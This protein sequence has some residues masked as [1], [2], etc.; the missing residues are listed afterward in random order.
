MSDETHAARES[1][2]QVHAHLSA[3]AGRS[4]LS[5]ARGAA[6]LLGPSI[7][8]GLVAPFVF[9]AMRRAAGPVVK[10]LLK[11]ALSLGESIKDGAVEARE[12][13]ADTLAE[14]K[15]EREREAAAEA[16]TKKTDG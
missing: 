7:I 10:G 4:L 15:A 14:V 12:R 5:G 11:G 16:A 2:S 9:P 1:I 8:V 13:I 3:S 6:R